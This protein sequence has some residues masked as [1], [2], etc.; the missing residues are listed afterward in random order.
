MAEAEV[1][2]A[3]AG[4]GSDGENPL[5]VMSAQPWG[6]AP[7]NPSLA[8]DFQFIGLYLLAATKLRH[9][10]VFTRVCHSVHRG[11]G[12]WP[13]ACWDTPTAPGPGADTPSPGPEADPSDQEQT[14]RDQE[15]TL[16]RD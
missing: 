10:Y 6:L 12:V 5:T 4:W 16:P 7:V 2:E 15:Q 8:T 3:D 14:P 1:A 9:G 11:G 13:I